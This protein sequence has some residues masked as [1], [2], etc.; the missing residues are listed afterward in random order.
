MK[1]ATKHAEVLKGLFR[2]LVREHKPAPK[3]PLN[4]EL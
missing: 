3:E 1:N 4:D 2:R